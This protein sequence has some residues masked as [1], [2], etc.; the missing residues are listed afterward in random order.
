MTYALSNN[1]LYH[2]PLKFCRYESWRSIYHLFCTHIDL[3]SHT[4]P[5]AA[6]C[7]LAESHRY[8]IKSSTSKRVT[9][10][11]ILYHRNYA[12]EHNRHT[13]TFYR[14]LFLEHS[15]TTHERWYEGISVVSLRSVVARDCNASMNLMIHEIDDWW[16]SIKGL[17]QRRTA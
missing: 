8:T 14:N 4:T 5:L 7:P 10:Y 3:I 16:L 12:P 17:L 9:T 15:M 6:S 1:N 13:D 11:F 2:I